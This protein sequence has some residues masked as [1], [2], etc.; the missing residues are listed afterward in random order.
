MFTLNNLFGIDYNSDDE[1]PEP[2]LSSGT[3]TEQSLDSSDC[4]ESSSSDDDD[5]SKY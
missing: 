2:S 5:P 4:V 3:T 1:N